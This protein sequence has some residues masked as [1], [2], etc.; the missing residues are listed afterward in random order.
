M[1]TVEINAYWR[2]EVEHGAGRGDPLLA[3][4]FASVVHVL[5]H[6]IPHP[7]MLIVGV[8]AWVPWVHVLVRRELHN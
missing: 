1:V 4:L 6:T 3:F 2:E 7:T 5:F 8:Y